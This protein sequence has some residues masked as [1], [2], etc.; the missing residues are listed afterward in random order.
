VGSDPAVQATFRE[1]IRRLDYLIRMVG[2]SPLTR[3]ILDHA[4]KLWADCR[5]RGLP[6]TNEDRIDIDV[7]VAAEAVQMNA[8][9]LTQNA[10]DFTKHGLKIATL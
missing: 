8:E 7:I 3:E 2:L 4:A 6:N 9:V 10:K 5:G 1:S